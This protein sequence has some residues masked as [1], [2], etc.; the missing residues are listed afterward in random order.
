MVPRGRN[1]HRSRARD[2]KIVR[3]EPCTHLELIKLLHGSDGDPGVLRLAGLLQGLGPVRW[4]GF[5]QRC[6]PLFFPEATMGTAETRGV[7]RVS[8][9]ISG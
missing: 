1:A 7:G 4:E 3:D 6:A 2:P 5:R 9:V 8:R